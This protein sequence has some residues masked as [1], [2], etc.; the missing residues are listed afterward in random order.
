[1][2]EG[3]KNV[4]YA[5]AFNNPFGDRVRPGSRAAR[6]LRLAPVRCGDVH[7]PSLGVRVRP[8]H[9]P[10]APA[11]PL[12]AIR[13]PQ[14]A[15]GSFDKTAKIWDANTG[16]LYHTFRGHATEIVCLAFNPA[17][18]VLATGS[19]DNTAKVR[20]APS[21]SLADRAL[22]HSSQRQSRAPACTRHCAAS[23]RKA[24][25]RLSSPPPAHPFLTSCPVPFPT[26][27]W[28]NNTALGRGAR[29]G[30]LH[31]PGPHGGDREPVLQHGGVADRHGVVR[32][33][34]KGA[35]MRWRMLVAVVV[36]RIVLFDSHLLELQARAFATSPLRFLAPSSPLQSA[37]PSALAHAAEAADPS[38]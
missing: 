20:A 19:M 4:V 10:A 35:R 22:L 3:H 33:R 34:R 18:T 9:R 16:Q 6:S 23:A 7:P 28:H 2:L 15:T 38:Y 32:L 8:A 17:S 12:S 26:Q 30:A 37:A 13:Y 24:S 11:A 31:P 5:I 14:V 36:G 21:L 27:Q 25:P 29:G 1:M